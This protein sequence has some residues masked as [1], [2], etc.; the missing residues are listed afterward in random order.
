[1]AVGAALEAKGHKTIYVVGEP[2]AFVDQ[3]GSRTPSELH[4]APVLSA[5]PQLVMKRPPVDGFADQMAVAGY[6]NRQSLLTLASIWNR[7]LEA[8]KPDMIVGFRTPVLWL[9]GQYH[10]PT[11]A[12]GNGFAMPPILGT[13]FPRLSVNST[14]LAEESIMLANANAVLARF[15]KPALASLS[16]VLQGCTSILYGPPP[17][18]PY[19]QLRRTLTIG[20]LGENP[21]PSNPPTRPR[22]AVFLDV[23]CPGVETIVLA[24][25]GLG[26]IPVDIHISGVTTGMR[27]FLEQQPHIKVWNDHAALLAQVETASALV[28]HGVHDVAQRCLT[29]GRPQLM[30]PWTRE[31]EMLTYMVG[32]MSFS[33]T[34][35]STTE[36][37]EMSTTLRDLL[38]DNSLVVAA[39]HHARQF[40]DTNLPNALP[41]IVGQLEKLVKA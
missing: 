1:M 27:R 19:L 2:V 3:A 34:K 4:Q 7:Q 23:R 8:L 28:H 17:L 16:E 18:D 6:D 38:R 15:G 12:I 30:I 22:L 9:I 41:A 5:M 31:Q 33:W 20:L 35:P 10:A 11:V 40:A 39:Q 26:T 37:A 25:S 32:W 14:P 24:V 21:Q 36:V 13:S 29:K